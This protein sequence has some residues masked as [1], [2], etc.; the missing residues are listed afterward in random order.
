MS[1][2][3]FTHENDP[4]MTHLIAG[5]GKSLGCFL[6]TS[7]VDWPVV[8]TEMEISF[9]ILS[10]GSYVASRNLGF[11]KPYLARRFGGR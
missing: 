2:P 1:K 11:M 3:H 7:S 4:K 8:K 10:L 6:T 9:L 5:R